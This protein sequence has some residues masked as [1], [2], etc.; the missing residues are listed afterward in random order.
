M[1]G[2]HQGES[3]Y[4]PRLRVTDKYIIL[5]Y[6]SIPMNIGAYIRRCYI[7]QFLH[8]LIKEYNVY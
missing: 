6:S 7:P 1:A 5:L 2:A 3:Q 8:P 4:I